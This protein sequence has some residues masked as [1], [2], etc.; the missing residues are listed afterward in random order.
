MRQC[1]RSNHADSYPALSY[2]ELYV[3]E[4]GYKAFYEQQSSLCS[5]RDYV[6]MSQPGCELQLRQ[7]RAECKRDSRRLQ[8]HN[9]SRMTLT[10]A[11]SSP[12]DNEDDSCRAPARTLRF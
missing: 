2:P 10:L 9:A 11:S 1:D 7:Y 4:G 12:C 3:L 8:R 6:P 5:P